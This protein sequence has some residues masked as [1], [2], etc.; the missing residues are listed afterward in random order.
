MT[1]A[2]EFAFVEDH[3]IPIG[4]V[5]GEVDIDNASRLEDLLDRL[6]AR[7]RGVVIVSLERTTY[8]DSRAI[9]SLA[10]FLARI[11]VNRQ[12]AYLVLPALESGRRL[13][14]ITGLLRNLPVFATL[15]AAVEAA[16]QL[17]AS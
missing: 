8:F 4:V 11:R 9:H 12:V 13:L 15:A 10:S 1:G 7:D 14:E 17:P 5:S 6:A 2:A 3:G 16:Q